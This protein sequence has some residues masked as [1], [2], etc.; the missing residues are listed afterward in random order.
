MP[1]AA[2]LDDLQLE[3]DTPDYYIYSTIRNSDV[4]NSPLIETA[5]I[6]NVRLTRVITKL[7]RKSQVVGA[8]SNTLG[9]FPDVDLPSACEQNLSSLTTCG[10]LSPA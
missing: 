7:I 8:P 2:H 5:G 6:H 9:L 10:V 4:L 1:H 3:R